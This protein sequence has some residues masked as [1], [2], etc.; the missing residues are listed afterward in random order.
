MIIG[1]A[2]FGNLSILFILFKLIYYI[3]LKTTLNTN[4]KLLNAYIFP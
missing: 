1:N 4:L 2:T 3:F